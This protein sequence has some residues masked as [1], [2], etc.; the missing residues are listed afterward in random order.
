[1]ATSDDSKKLHIA[2]FPWLAFGHLLP[3]LDLAKLLAQK[4][5]TISFISTPR[6]L[7][8][9]PK[10]KIP[11]NL[12]S[13][14]NFVPISLPQ[15]ENLPQNAEST[16]DVPYD[17]VPY[18][19]QAFDHTKFQQQFASFIE[20]TNPDWIIYDF[21]HHWLPPIAVKHGVS[22]AFFSIFNAWSLV[23]S[24]PSP[25]DDE[26][27][28][29]DSTPKPEHLTVPRKWV[30]F[31]SNVA[32]RLHEAKKM[33][34]NLNPNVSGVSDLFRVH[35]AVLGCEV[36]LIRSCVHIEAEW[37]QLLQDMY[38]RP[39]VPVG[40][41]PPPHHVSDNSENN[42]T[43]LEISSFL[44]KQKKNF[45]VYIALGS[46]VEPSRD[47]FTELAHGLELSGLNA[48]VLEEKKVG[49]E[50]PRNEEDGSFTRNS[51]AA[52]VRLLVFDQEGEVYRENVK[53][54]SLIFADED[55]HN[56]Y[57]DHLAKYLIMHA[58]G[59]STMQSSG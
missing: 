9:L 33:L 5:H 25:Y 3:Y 7:N 13:S 12:L 44:D 23:N 8:R 20:T 18:L 4:G 26:M 40:L 14:I 16:T 58:H 42:D 41:L 51:V 28:G 57:I 1:M 2:M 10:F 11:P 54:M 37:I 48:R 24:G 19:K 53:E 34:N 49:L 15:I 55:L 59:S 43:W 45:V 56:Q 17:T 31:K 27:D 46:E 21:A 32:F 22:R 29:Q 38:R 50:I 30:P 36:L 47:D 35:K 6:N 39:V 52:S